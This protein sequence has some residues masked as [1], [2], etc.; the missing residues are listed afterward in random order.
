MLKVGII[1]CGFMG[2]MHAT[3][4]GQ[5]DQAELVGVYDANETKRNE[6]AAANNIKSFDSLEALLAEVDAVDICLPTYKHCEFV[7]KAAAARKHVL[8][9]KPIA[10]SIPE[11]EQMKAACNEAGVRFMVAHCIRFWPEYAFLKQVALTGNLGEILSLN[12]TRYGEFPSWGANNWLADETKAGGGALDMHI[13]DTDF[14]IYLLGHPDEVF[15]A[16]TVDDKGV[17]HI[18]ST[19]VYRKAIC[20]LEGGW[21]LPPQTPFKMAFRAIFEQGAIIMDGG[22]LTVYEKDKAPFVPEFDKMEAKGGGNISDLGGYYH[23]IAHFV[24]RVLTDKPFDVTTPDTSIESLRLTLREI[25][26]SKKRAAL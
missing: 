12:L 2:R 6:F 7:L 26:L 9:E 22:P 17:S 4:Y 10:L 11:A 8:C 25:E 24:D 18:F 14:A 1:G 21:N 3:V 23:E 5:V 16:G 15:S 20:H 13:H 19:F